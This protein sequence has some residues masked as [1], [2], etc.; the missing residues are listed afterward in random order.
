MEKQTD[1]ALCSLSAPLKR[2]IIIHMD[3][4]IDGQS[5]VLFPSSPY[6]EIRIVKEEQTDE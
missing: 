3:E 2:G 5:S 4:Q 6:R 1:E